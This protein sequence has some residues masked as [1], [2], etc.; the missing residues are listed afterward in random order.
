MKR[1]ILALLL[2]SIRSTLLCY[3]QAIVTDPTSYAYYAQQLAAQTEQHM[4][5]TQQ[6]IQA[7]ESFSKLQETVKEAKKQTT[8][9]KDAR[10]AL[11]KVNSKLRTLGQVERTLSYNKSTLIRTKDAIAFCKQSE[12][13]SD[14]EIGNI[15]YNFTQ[16]T[17]AT[18]NTLSLL[19]AVLKDD[20]FEMSDAERIELLTRMENEARQA[21]QDVDLLYDTYRRAV[22]RR[23]MVEFFSGKK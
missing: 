19:N 21:R 7:Q 18:N 16:L 3:G 8:F 10:K 6:L 2:L 14:R 11:Q 20:F 9:I 17:N 5:A 1:T 13:F 12:Q 4:T 22:D 23:Q 15:L